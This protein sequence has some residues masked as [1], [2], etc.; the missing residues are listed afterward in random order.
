MST[1]TRDTIIKDVQGA[2]RLAVAYIG[3]SSGLFVALEALKVATSA[4][5]AH[6]CARDEAYVLRWCD[7]AYAFELLDEESAGF[8]LTDLGRA[9]LPGAP[10]TLMPFAVQEVL[11]AHMAERVVGLM[12]TGERPG[13]SV[14]AEQES[15]LPWFGPMLEA[16]FGPIFEKTILPN[17]P[18]YA[19]AADKEGLAVDLGCGNGW[20]LLR[21]AR[22]FPKIRVLGIDGFEENIRQANVRAQQEG[23]GDRVEFRVGDIYSFKNR[24]SASI[25]A[26]NRALH[27][28]WDQ[29]SRVFD[30]LRDH[31]KPGGS[32]VIWEPYWSAK[33]EALRE[34]ARR[35]MVFQN[36]TEHVQGNHFLEP[37][38]VASAF[39][40]VGLMPKIMPFVDGRE[41][42]IIGTRPLA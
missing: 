40:E 10:N 3:I 42:I 32:A 19:E 2:V 37:T 38:E 39:Q 15:V 8:R 33:R 23:L 9:F 1:V 28:V 18:V 29:K 35:M 13:E 41:A 17:V 22:H 34:P 4:R 20:Y 36:L 14:L 16:Q 31:L 21:L 12:T 11:T 24:E 6:A 27:H 25:I 26:L 5:L 7:A 30:I